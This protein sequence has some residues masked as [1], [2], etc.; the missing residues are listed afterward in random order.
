MNG[1]AGLLLPRPLAGEPVAALETGA[2]S[3]PYLARLLARE[4]AT[5][6]DLAG[7]GP[8]AVLQ[9]ILD[10]LARLS[11]AAGEAEAMTG[12]RHAKRQAHLVI[13][14]ADLC[15]IWPLAEV[16]G[17]MTRFADAAAACALA[18]AART[19]GHPADGLFLVALGKMGAHELNYSS[20]I[21]IAA[22][23]D[24]DI[25]DAGL[26]GAADA[27]SRI[28]RLMTR[29]LEEPTGDG[30]VLRTD[31]RL[32]PDPRSTPVAV[33]TRMAGQYY[34][35]L[36]QNW[37]RMVWIKARP[38]AGDLAAAARFLGA[39]RPFVW[40]QHLDYWAIAD[41]RAIKAMINAT[42][43]RADLDAPHA[44][45]KLGPGGIREI[46]FF[47]QTQQLI[48]GGRD[49]SLR[50]RST[51]GALQALVAAGHVKA[52]VAERLKAAY[53]VLRAVE[54]RAQMRLDEQTHVLPKDDAKR[55]EIA[56]LSGLD[57]LGAFDR[58][59][60]E[61]RSD[62]H[63]IY[64][65]LF[66]HEAREA[67]AAETGNLV[68]TGV[69]DDPGTVAT[70]AAMGFRETSATIDAIRNW[71]RGYLPAT[72]TV[73]GREI[74]TALLPR[75]LADMGTTG[76]A[77]EAFRRFSSFME[78]LPSG[79]QTLSML[80]AE[81]N[82][83]RDLVATLAL[84]PRLARTLGRR[85]HLIEAL[86]Q[87]DQA[88]PLDAGPDQPFGDALDS[89]RR[90]V[91]DRA[92]LIGHDL[93]HGRI[94]ARDAAFAYSDLAD[95]TVAAMA[96]AAETETGRRFGPPPGAWSVVAL[97]KLG[98]RA[99]TASSDLDLMVLYESG[100][101]GD[102]GAWFTRFTQRLIT[103]L[104][105]ET[106]E[107]SLYEVDMRLRPSGRAGPVAVS[108]ESFARYHREDAWTW[109]H[110]AL[111][112]LRPVAGRGALG[113]KV[114]ALACTLMADAPRRDTLTGD[115]R[116]MRERLAREKP[117]EGLWDLKTGAGGLVDMEFIVQRE[118]LMAKGPREPLP[119]LS[120]AVNWLLGHGRL[121]GNDAGTLLNANRILSSLQQIQ[122]LALTGHVDPE[123]VSSGLKDRLAR[124]IGVA[125]F[126]ATEEA[127]RKSKAA[128]LDLRQARIGVVEGDLSAF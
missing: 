97:G 28:V 117:G 106:A 9:R 121:N 80:L 47:A 15:G 11:G 92:F 98:G 45:V 39:M 63:A 71:H 53:G 13:S 100:A 4:E 116:D 84:A 65:D 70:L 43:A 88:S 57:D 75:L 93:L 114:Q 119:V 72:R 1:A 108:L 127:L 96:A 87:P 26:R 74:L 110:M 33:S 54:H 95:R 35:T 79:V 27:A 56:R 14:A 81:P 105:A 32:R 123:T 73:R 83:R 16:T 90:H 68:F 85:P 109:E 67:S 49:P 101:D 21:D 46:E 23:Y 51:E 77:D 120:D 78:G 125:D 40:R 89:A 102:A 64:L 113:D 17:A 42:A 91:R 99:M 34:E 126:A 31:L 111:T 69:D 44:D 62:V 8:D 10:G 104:S 37:E 25:F 20:D 58:I 55:L 7:A 5:A 30:Y 6:T 118:L 38:F 36:G 128:V 48:L 19:L 29:L 82:L 94:A 112:R 86:L 122:R 103:A 76:E 24:P 52:E 12:L 41:I 50:E 18:V 22:F 59:L 60:R 66:G 107:G 115:I 2:R 124:A 3:A 61:V